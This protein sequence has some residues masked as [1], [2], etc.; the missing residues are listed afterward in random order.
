MQVK[1]QLLQPWLRGASK[2]SCDA[3]TAL[4]ETGRFKVGDVVRVRTSPTFPTVNPRT[5]PYALGHVGKVIKAYGVIVNPQD[6]HQPYE[7]LYTL[8]FDAAQIWGPKASHVVVA[9]VHDEWLELV[10]Q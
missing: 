1:R 7:P 6:H 10:P 3:M 2:G 9:E 8:E 4:V 5:P